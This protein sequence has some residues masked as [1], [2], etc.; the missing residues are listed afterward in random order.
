MPRHYCS[1]CGHIS[2]NTYHEYEI[3]RGVAHGIKTPVKPE[4]ITG[5]TPK[6]IV[7]DVEKTWLK[8]SLIMT[9]APEERPAIVSNRQEHLEACRCNECFNKKLDA[10]IAS[11]EAAL[12]QGE[13]DAQTN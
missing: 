12:N 2:F 9:D 10:L 7:A 11:Q 1:M 6:K 13:S 3:H 8:D 4:N 5:R